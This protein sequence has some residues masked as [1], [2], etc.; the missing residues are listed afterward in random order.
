MDPKNSFVNWK[1]SSVSMMNCVVLVVNRDVLLL[2][3]LFRLRMT[4]GGG[5]FGF[6][7]FCKKSCSSCSSFNAV[8]KKELG[9]YDKKSE[10]TNPPYS[11]NTKNFATSL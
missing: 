4:L 7:Y 1:D 5:S 6:V 8:S 11:H 9:S 10:M 3:F 2:C